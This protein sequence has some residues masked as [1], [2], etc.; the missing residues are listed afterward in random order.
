RVAGG[1]AAL[2]SLHVVALL[3]ARQA[4][5]ADGAAADWIHLTTQLLFVG[6]FVALVWL[7]AVYPD[8]RPS[9][10]LVGGAVLVGLTGPMLA[11]VSGPTPSVL[12]EGRELG[13]VVHLLPAGVA[14]VTVAPLMVLPL[15]A[16]I[17]FV[18]RYRRGNRNQRVAMRWPIAA[19]AVIAT[20]VIAGTALGTE[21]QGVVTALFLLAAPV[22]P[23]AL[24]FGPVVRHL[25]ALS[26]ELA[27]LRSSRRPLLRPD[28]APG[29]MSGLTAREL[30]V[31]EAMAGGMSNPQIAKSLHLSLSSVEKHATSIFR[32]LQ[33]SDEPT[34]H[35]RVS[36]VVAY[37]DAIESTRG[38][39]P[40]ATDGAGLSER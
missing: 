3:G 26:N 35:R 21:Q 28:A 33:V 23:L 32:K 31:L 11:A 9:A 5:A 2:G 24:A 7:A 19:L 38:S 29:A 10:K 1:L 18:V 13:P 14:A 17:T 15:L 12:D 8:Q 20:L 37:R 36:A 30:T 40:D 39:G 34:T 27:G 6:G 25:D 4:L 16:V 22:L